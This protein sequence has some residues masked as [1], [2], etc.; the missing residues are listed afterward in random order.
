VQANA[1]LG[2]LTSALP[3][4]AVIAATPQFTVWSGKYIAGMKAADVA[5][6]LRALANQIPRAELDRAAKP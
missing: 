6:V 5:T 1:L 2:E 3:R 4:N